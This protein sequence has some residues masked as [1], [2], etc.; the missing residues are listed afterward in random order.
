MT[1]VTRYLVRSAPDQSAADL[2]DAV[3]GLLARCRVF[4]RHLLIDI[5]V[6]PVV[7]RDWRLIRCVWRND[8]QAQHETSE[9]CPRAEAHVNM[10]DNSLTTGLVCRP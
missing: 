2:D 5:E 10:A 1:C 4:F 3:D 9:Q 6:E 7:G 8:E